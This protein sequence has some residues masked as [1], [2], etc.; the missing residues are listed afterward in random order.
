MRKSEFYRE[1]QGLDQKKKKILDSKSNH[2]E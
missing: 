1:N 2:T